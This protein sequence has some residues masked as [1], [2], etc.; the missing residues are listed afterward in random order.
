MAAMSER[1]SWCTPKWLT[2]LL[3][4]V[5]LDPCSNPRSTVHA[6]RTL[7]LEAGENGL[8]SQWWGS[9]VF[10]NPPFSNIL[11]WASK[12][13]DREPR[14]AAAFLVNVDPSCTW[15][16][17]LTSRL[18]CALMFSKRIQFDPPPGVQPSMNSKAQA[19][20]MNEPFLAM[21]NSGLLSLGT[22]WQSRRAA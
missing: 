7:S 12:L 17:V 10:V 18:D 8:A 22:V 14:H 20:L 11:P 16:K 1:D 15:W 13:C 4:V 3:P 21:C 19:L 9:S 6:E 2:D 5:S